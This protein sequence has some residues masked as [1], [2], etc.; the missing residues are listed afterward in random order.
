MGLFPLPIASFFLLLVKIKLHRQFNRE[1][2]LVK[3]HRFFKSKCQPINLYQFSHAGIKGSRSENLGWV[4]WWV[5][6][7]LPSAPLLP[8]FLL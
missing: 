4:G 6:G 5:G 1:K 3:S 2:P 8:L 7:V